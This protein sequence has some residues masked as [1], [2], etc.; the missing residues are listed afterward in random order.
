MNEHPEELLADYVEGTLDADARA[1]VEDHLAGCD[2]CRDE[3]ELAREARG[4]LGSLPELDVPSGIPLGVRRRA[5]RA[6]PS[7]V[8]RVAGIA[9]AASVLAAGTIY[10][11]SRIDIGGQESAETNA[12][13]DAPS[14]EGEAPLPQAAEEADSETAAAGAATG[15]RAAAP[16]LPTYL[17]TRREYEPKDLAPLARRLRDDA[18]QALE[19]G[20]QPTA[21]RFFQRFDFRAFTVQVRQAIRC[22]LTEVP[23]TQLIVPFRIEAASFEGTPAYIAAFLQGPTPDDQYDSL[24]IWVVDRE[25]CSLLSLAR[26]VL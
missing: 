9:V 21:T 11:L 15:V 14:G 18:L 7:R 23:P 19:L 16:A 6:G 12:Q 8:Q 22:V 3:L 1:R 26:Q 5:R 10:G 24:V 17:E 2:R 25:G 20:I 4:A 13:S